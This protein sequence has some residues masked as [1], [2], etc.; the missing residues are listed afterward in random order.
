VRYGARIYTLRPS[1]LTSIFSTVLTRAWYVLDRHGIPMT[2]VLE[3]GASP[4]VTAPGAFRFKPSVVPPA[5]IAAGRILR[6][7]PLQPRLH[8]RSNARCDR[9]RYASRRQ[10][11]RLE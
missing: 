10:R 2:A 1:E 6:F 4:P 11:N 3:E 9:V 7:E 5:L 8:G